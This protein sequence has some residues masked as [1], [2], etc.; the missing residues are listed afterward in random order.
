MIA[1]RSI[2]F[3]FP[4]PSNFTRSIAFLLKPVGMKTHCS[5]RSAMYRFCYNYSSNMASSL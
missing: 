2:D 4:V 1:D 5:T 3:L